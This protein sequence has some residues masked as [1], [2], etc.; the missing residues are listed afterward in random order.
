MP[1]LLEGRETIEISEAKNR[2]F[3]VLDGEYHHGTAFDDEYP[4]FI[5]LADKIIEDLISAG[6]TIP[7][8]IT[9]GI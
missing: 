6:V 8:D 9:P 5:R 1:D 2:V 7:E 4:N 3:G